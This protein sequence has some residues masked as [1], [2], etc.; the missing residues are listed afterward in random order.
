MDK[1][2]KAISN[3]TTYDVLSRDETSYDIL[4]KY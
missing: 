4:Q 2:F 3:K 1:M